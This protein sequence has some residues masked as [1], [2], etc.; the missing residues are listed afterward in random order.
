MKIYN[1]RMSLILSLI[2]LVK[3]SATQ[4]RGQMWS[5][6]ASNSWLVMHTSN[7]IQ[8]FSLNRISI[9]VSSRVGLQVGMVIDDRRCKCRCYTPISHFLLHPP[10]LRTGC[11]LQFF[12][13]YQ[14]KPFLEPCHIDRRRL[15]MLR[16]SLDSEE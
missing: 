8:R 10:G 12:R 14:I 6:W 3:E 11:R 2:G 5:G 16:R 9:C 4:G 13:F 15:L 7:L 1:Q